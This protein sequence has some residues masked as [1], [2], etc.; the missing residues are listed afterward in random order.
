MLQER[1]Q[2]LFIVF[3]GID[4]SG[5]STQ[6]KLLAQR[7][8]DVGHKVYSTFEP[9]YSPIGSLVRNIFSNRIQADQQTIA[10]LNVAD[11]LD[12]LHNQVN[13]ILKKLREGFTVISD[14]YY[15]SSYAYHGV[16]VDIDWVIA[17]NALAAQT[18]RPDVNLFIDVPPEVCMERLQGTRNNIDMYET[19]DNLSLVRAKYLEAFEKLGQQEQIQFVNGSQSVQEIAAEVWQTVAPLIRK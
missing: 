9:T 6:T 2:P 7:L 12:H 14:R 16:H 4:G 19:L 10:A 15:F 13:G 18:L 17:A 5:K 8:S 11:R 3:E 1:V